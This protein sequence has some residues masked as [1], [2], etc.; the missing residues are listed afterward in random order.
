[1]PRRCTARSPKG[2]R[3]PDLQRSGWALP[4]CQRVIL[5]RAG[6]IAA[7]NRGRTIT[8]FFEGTAEKYRADD[9]HV[10][11]T[12]ELL[13]TVEEHRLPSGETHYVEVLKAPVYNAA[14]AVAGIQIAFWD[15]TSRRRAEQELSE[16]EARNRSI[17]QPLSTALSRSTR[18]GRLSNSTGCGNRIWLSSRRDRRQRPGRHTVS[19]ATRDRHRDTLDVTPTR[20]NWVRCWAGGS[21]RR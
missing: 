16:S 7:G 20:V 4:I 18:K 12:R 14:G 17:L 1:M 13:Q 2:C 15:V 19:T 6:Q 8:T 11:E 21:S 9:L 3:S 10:S 5:P